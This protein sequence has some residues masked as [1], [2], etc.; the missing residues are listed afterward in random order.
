MRFL[1]ALEPVARLFRERARRAYLSEGRAHVELGDL[2]ADELPRFERGLRQLATADRRVSRLEVNAY[3]RRALF[4]FEPGMCTLAELIAWVEE[5]ER[6]AGVAAARFEGEKEHPAD[7]EPGLRRLVGL[8]AD[9][10]AFFAGLGLSVTP[11]PAFPFA[12]TASAVLS[13]VGSVDRLRAGIEQRIGPERTELFLDLGMAAF[14]AL[15]QRPLTSFV[16]GV[17]KLGKF[18]E[19]QA[20]R[21]AWA[22]LEPQL[23]RDPVDGIVG[24]PKTEQRPAEMPRGP[25][26][27]YAD[28]AW[29]VSLAGFAVSF[30]TTR[31]LQRAI[32]ALYGSLPRPARL[33]RD[34]FSA[35]LSRILAARDTLV[36]D[37]GALRRL[38]RIDTLVLQGDL[39]SAN[40]FALG[41]MHCLPGVEE[42]PLRAALEELFNP[43]NPL[44]RQSA[45]GFH[46]GPW[47]LSPTTA[48][49]ALEET[50]RSLARSG[51]L[52]LSLE[53]HGE[54]VAAVE[55]DI[56]A[57]TGL[58]ELVAAAHDAGM[59]VVIASSDDTILQ[60]VSADDV[61]GDVEGMRAGIRR[62]QRDGR[63]VCLVAKGDSPGL[64]IADFGIGICRPSEGTPWGAHVLCPDDLAE[65]RL[66]IRACVRS[67]EVSKQSVNIALGAAAFGALVSA[68]GLLPLTSRR[69]VFVV[70]MATLMSMANGLRGSIA[71]RRLALPPSRDPTPWHALDADG[72]LG[73]LST[74]RQGLSQREVTLR[75]AP[76]IAGPTELRELGEAI[77]DEL[78]NPL[79]PLLAA[80]AG[81]S[82]AVGS[83]S[84]AV[85]VG[86]VVGFNALVGGGQR[87][88]T[89]RKLRILSRSERRRAL[90]RREG[91]A[92]GVDA[93]ALVPGDVVVLAAGDVVP[94]DCR[95]L[96]ASLLEVDASSLTGESLPVK[97]F[98]APSFEE[99]A[100]DRSSM[101]Y[102]GTT[103]VAGQATAVVVAVGAHTEARRGAAGSRAARASAGVERRLRGLMSLTGPVALAAGVGVVGGG[104]LRG[105]KLEDLVGSGVSLAVASVPEGLPLL[106][107]AAQLAASERLSRRHALVRNPRALEA[108]G[109]VDVVCLD[110]TGTITEGAL[111]LSVVSDGEVLASVE[112]LEKSHRLVLSA[113]LRATLGGDGIPVAGDPTDE[114]LARGAR[115]AG[116]DASY[117]CPGFR[118]TSQLSLALARSYHAVLGRSDDGARLSVK[119]APE[120]LLLQCTHRMHGGVPEPLDDAGRL[121][122]FSS[123]TQLAAQGLRVLAVAERAAASDAT[124]DPALDVDLTFRGFLAFRD[125]IRETAAAAVLSMRAAGVET[126]MITGDHPSTAEAIARELDLLGSRQVMTGAELAALSDGELDRRVSSVAVFARVTPSQKVRIVRAL[127]RAGRVVAMAGDG[128]NDAA[129][130]RLADA[131]IAIGEASTHAA[132]AAA[133]IVVMD[134][135]IETIVDAIAEG[136]AMWASVRDAVSI[137][138][139]GN[140]GEIGFTLLAGLIDGTP[141]LHARQLLL[142]NLFTDIAPAMAVALKPPAPQAFEALA[143]ETPDAALGAPLDRQIATRA[144]TTAAGAGTAWA[145]GR[146]LGSRSKARTIGLAALVGT[147]L[148]QTIT[149]GEFSRPVVLTSIASAGALSLLIQTPGVSHFFGCRPLGPIAW[150]TA[151]GASVAATMLG[152]AVSKRM[153]E[154]G[155]DAAGAVASLRAAGEAIGLLRPA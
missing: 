27:E 32:A 85:M 128:A 148:G 55:V 79:A 104:L 126:V 147:Q 39:V 34:V 105:R 72:V 117:G 5:A 118:R 42:G 21:G 141:P 137:L 62:L 50:A 1:E 136:R 77:T 57:R 33:G 44:S 120:V 116:V 87:F 89:E 20:Q 8:A 65:V 40:A 24:A 123:A 35:E 48:D 37:A 112:A 109:R 53:R 99:Q 113:G 70:N 4:V 98:A 36:L 29:I 108:L 58:D 45:N 95:I 71:I 75:R 56:T 83:I 122:L 66:L 41:P 59:R 152:S 68:G 15:A 90:V 127:Q 143:R 46:L 138:I 10:G 110:K 19:A 23:A 125:P 67:R 52:V 76:T 86:G 132:R 145:V 30:A 133:D 88:A 119:G 114:A 73:R 135:R 74:V 9:T 31:S 106:A 7:V 61:I 51:A 100:A 69:V 91:Q 84:D 121:G 12:G 6:A 134:G 146:I 28:R 81:L 49:A 43:D 60:A 150:T 144:F 129:A 107:T 2:G 38:D 102:E 16:D 142:V 18:R 63:G 153:Q 22:R 124:L 80:G 13:F 154:Q 78:F 25:I 26:E 93:T 92:E 130:I 82:A 149:S 140:L 94:A 14:A 97:K 111:S 47:K 101:I 155:P 151:I 139:G 64:P 103:V 17:H 131:G 11:L 96:E 115:R 54:V 3:L